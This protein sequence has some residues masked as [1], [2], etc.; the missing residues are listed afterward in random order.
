M[1]NHFLSH[2]DSHILWETVKLFV[3]AV[4]CITI[5]LVV[6]TTDNIPM[7]LLLFIGIVLIFYA[8]LYPW[9]KV[10]YYA[11]MSVLLVILFIFLLW[12]GTDILVKME[13]AGISH[14][15]GAEAVA[16]LS[17]FVFFAGFIAGIIGILR[18]K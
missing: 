12:L 3:I 6:G 10:E 8:L 11:V 7:I 2:F 1:K 9:G 15:H 17:G 18:F 5:S 16:M 13:A 14:V 4:S